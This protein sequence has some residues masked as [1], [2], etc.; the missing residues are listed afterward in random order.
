LIVGCARLDFDAVSR[1]HWIPLVCLLV[2]A[3]VA[4]GLRVDATSAVVGPDGIWLRDNDTLRRLEFTNNVADPAKPYPWKNPRDG[5]PE[6]SVIHWTLPMSWAIA[7]LDSILASSYPNAR[8]FEA[9]ALWIGVVL[10]TIS[11]LLFGLLSWRLLGRPWPA[12]VATA[13]FAFSRPVIG[14]TELGNGDHQSLQSLMCVGALLSFAIA[15]A[16]RGGPTFMVIGGLALGFA[17]WVST[18]SM[19]VLQLI[20]VGSFL[21][22]AL[23]PPQSRRAAVMQHLAWAGSALIVMILGDVFEHASWPNL[24]WDK[25]SVFQTW[26]LSVFLGFLGLVPVLGRIGFPGRFTVPVLSAVVSVL[27][28]GLL[29]FVH[30]G[31]R[32][33]FGA[34]YD[35]FSA[36]NAWVQSQVEE[37]SSLLFV[38]GTFVPSSW[39][40]H[41]GFANYLLPFFLLGWFRSDAVGEARLPLGLI[42]LGL[43]GLTLVEVKLAHL[44][45]ILAP[46]LCVVGGCNL[47]DWFEAR[48]STGDDSVSTLARHGTRWI[49][50]MAAVLL[51]VPNLPE[52]EPQMSELD[53]AQR[54]VFATVKRLSG[55]LD[56]DDDV[57]SVLALWTDGAGLMYYADAPAVASGYH[58]NLSG[59]HDSWRV[60][61]C[62]SFAQAEPILRARKVRFVISIA[63]PEVLLNAAETMPELGPFA[64]RVEFV[65]GPDGERSKQIQWSRKGVTSLWWRWHTERKV[66]GFKIEFQSKLET[67]LPGPRGMVSLPLYRVWRVIYP[68]ERR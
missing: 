18:E 29:P 34:L 6:G 38:D 49:A 67:M 35:N 19:V 60:A 30:P 25:V 42:A 24:E 32:E 31:L 44:F 54:D 51:L 48:R 8:P 33:S 10:G 53:E 9:S 21:H 63:Q 59:I 58:R 28:I 43:L 46:I 64:D 45:L 27:V 12:V 36:S 17:N 20:G 2:L 26:Q 56:P 37:Y 47:L 61:G 52:G 23:L 39:G 16:G 7:G 66:P 68:E 15:V 5:A 22:I 57:R 4:F 65:R 55:K 11:V 50:G 3:A 41:L 14:T 13:L 1:A 40:V 62:T